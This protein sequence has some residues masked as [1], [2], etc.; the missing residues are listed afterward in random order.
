M[1]S[2]PIVLGAH[3]G[4]EFEELFDYIFRFWEIE[5]FVQTF[6]HTANIQNI[7]FVP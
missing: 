4:A 5:L 3:A 1:T 2:V 7:T 6:N